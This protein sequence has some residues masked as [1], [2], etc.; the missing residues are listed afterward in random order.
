M[1][2]K[3]LVGLLLILGL[4]TAA[5]A[6]ASDLTVRGSV[7][8]AD[9]QVPVEIS[10]ALAPMPSAY[11]WSRGILTGR[12]GPDPEVATELRAGGT[13]VLRAPRP[14]LWMVV[15]QGPGFVPIYHPSLALVES[16][17]LPPAVL[18]AD[19]GASLRTVAPGG[20]ALPGVR[21][22][23]TTRS[24]GLW[25]SLAPW[26]ALPRFYRTGEDGS[27]RVPRAAEERLAVRGMAPARKSESR[28][29]GE[30]P[31]SLKLQPAASCPV[32]VLRH[33]GEPAADVMVR[34]GN[35]ALP[36]SL[37]AEDGTA[38][39]P[40]SSTD[41]M[42]LRLLAQ[43]G[44]RH[45]VELPR[46][47]EGASLCPENF[48]IRL[49]RP[50][51]LSGRV[52]DLETSAPLAN[53]LVWPVHEMGLAQLTDGSGRYS[54][55]TPPIPRWRVWAKAKGY[56]SV[57][58]EDVY[59]P[60]SPPRA[61]SL[62]LEPAAALRGQVVDE[63]GQPVDDANI[64]AVPLTNFASQRF[65]SG[66]A[67]SGRDR[68]GAGGS[69]E[70]RGLRPGEEYELRAE[71]EDYA[72]ARLSVT[73][74]EPRR[75]RGGL[76]LVM[77]R[78]LRVVGQ[79]L[80]SDELPMT[81]VQVELVRAQGQKPRRG[82][83]PSPL[84]AESLDDGAFEIVRVPAGVYDVLLTR[85]GFVP[86]SLRG[87]VLPAGG[88]VVD[89]GSIRLEPGVTIEGRVVDAHDE[90]VTDVKVARLADA[91]EVMMVRNGGG[92]RSPPLTASNE[93]GRFAIPDLRRGEK[94]HLVFHHDKYQTA[95]IEGV[96]APTGQPVEVVLQPTAI[97]RGRVIDDSRRPVAGASVSAFAPHEEVAEGAAKEIYSRQT[98]AVRADPA[99]RFTLRVPPGEAWLSASAR[100]YLRGEEESLRLREGEA[101]EDV[102]IVL[103][104]GAVVQGKVRAS[105]GKP[106]LG[107][108]VAAGQGAAVSD[109]EGYYRV[110]GASIGRETVIVDHP[111][112]R[113]V[114]QEAEIRPGEQTL[115]FVLGGKGGNLRGRVVGPNGSG[116][117]GARVQ[118]TWS[119]T[120][121]NRVLTDDD[122]AFEF[123]SIARG[124][125]DIEVTKEGYARASE[126]FVLG[127]QSINDLVLE[128]RPGARIT[129]RLFGLGAGDRESVEVVARDAG[130]GEA[131]GLVLA[132]GTYEIK[133]LLPGD[134]EIRA[135]A[136][137][138]RRQASARRRLTAN[139]TV[140]NI[141]LDLSGGVELAGQVLH[142]SEPLAGASVTLR[143]HDVAAR[144]EVVTDHK[145]GFSFD[146][147][148][149]GSYRV[150]VLHQRELVNHSEEVTLEGDHELVI[151]LATSRLAGQVL[152]AET[153][154]PIKD[155]YILFDRQSNERGDTA[156]RVGVPSGG[157]GT[158]LV[159]RASSGRFRVRVQ[160]SGYEPMT[161]ELLLADGESREDLEFGLTPT[162]GLTIEPRM[163]GGG[164]PRAIAVA[165][166]DP[167]GVVR[168]LESGLLDETGR[169]HLRTLPAGEWDVVVTGPDVAL[170]PARVEIPAT[171][172]LRVVL[173][174]AS[175]LS[176][177]VPELASSKAVAELSIVDSGGQPWR[178][179]SGPDDA[180]QTRWRVVGGTAR[181]ESL[182]AGSYS[183]EVRSEDGRTW[184]G[185][186]TVTAGGN[187]EVRLGGAS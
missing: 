90:P 96:E 176:V 27:V 101:L 160:K 23:V 118:L 53:A 5:L 80:D 125:Y 43:T 68:S 144:R 104:R 161:D 67:P 79:A 165:V 35:G 136:G 173:E 50:V 36:A 93:D 74:L 7:V 154:E 89:L 17:E 110:E 133:D 111:S 181:L 126:S 177:H 30:G 166:V 70:I 98:A 130:D 138:G 158:F 170:H 14:G 88:G 103:K 157:D 141:D 99:G 34:L 72:M 121:P 116:I 151:E 3:P 112:Y 119:H 174:P 187:S 179:L 18:L 182:R 145:G 153:G 29:V 39:F 114:E 97:I 148:D 159:P 60:D 139:D 178:D 128:L 95:W 73:G 22:Y 115:D 55:P 54:V 120:R 180:M 185:S 155:A 162:P 19:A 156:F 77:T 94:V 8:T 175:R 168:A 83:T 135:E 13:F 172:P 47:A 38:E 113:P 85:T 21:L 64:N 45:E 59:H 164:L 58:H 41:P 66:K 12:F 86:M 91:R 122:G 107:A 16:V 32:Q 31:V 137:D 129:G 143:G 123:E 184:T 132:D 186:A 183:L 9:G 75:T 100:G 56:L 61:P 1:G 92:V 62:A 42:R 37:T 49:P 106:L 163:T 81:G 169:A 51:W 44:H 142:G 2:G 48:Q 52:L 117:E 146:G 6:G 11:E 25:K 149:E 108:R 167:S 105:N 76:S 65:Y 109:A 82:R 40:R 63:S 124:G 26:Q 152:D 127:E 78:G 134:W 102:E 171:E 150:Q 140:V 15:I 33:T 69:F 131:Y 28:G 87:I 46:P 24:P 57:G 10:V 84:N 71:H 147:L 4:L 20:Q